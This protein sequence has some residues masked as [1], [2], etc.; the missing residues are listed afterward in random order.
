MAEGCVEDFL[1]HLCLS[2]NFEGSYAH[3][4]TTNTGSFNFEDQ[5]LQKPQGH[6][7]LPVI[8]ALETRDRGFSEETGCQDIP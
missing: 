1:Y 5:N 4:Y 3:H 6:V 8:P 2:F 7:C